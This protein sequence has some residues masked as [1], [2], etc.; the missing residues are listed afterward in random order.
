[1]DLDRTISDTEEGIM[2]LFRDI[3]SG[4]GNSSSG[5][6]ST[7]TERISELKKELEIAQMSLD[8]M[9]MLAN[10]SFQDLINGYN[11]SGTR[12]FEN[13]TEM[14][15]VLRQLRIKTDRLDDLEEINDSTRSTKNNSEDNTLVSIVIL[16]LI[17]LIWILLLINLY[18]NLRKRS[19]ASE[20]EKWKIEDRFKKDE[21]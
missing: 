16:V 8:L 7:L 6:N 10:V 20:Y 4:I 5:P 1:M 17:A 13:L 15:E 11:E 9:F 21:D 14:N 19:Q 12:M 18:F 2:K 3:T